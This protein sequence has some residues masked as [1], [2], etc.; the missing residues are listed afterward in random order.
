MSTQHQKHLFIL[1]KTERLNAG[2]DCSTFVSS[3]GP[4]LTHN[5]SLM[6]DY[7]QT[8]VH[9]PCKKFAARF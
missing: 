9:H 1:S 3:V 8:V 2:A 6:S 7:C 5:A 4:T